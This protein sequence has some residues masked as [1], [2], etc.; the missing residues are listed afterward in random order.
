MLITVE[1]QSSQPLRLSPWVHFEPSD[2]EMRMLYVQQLEPLQDPFFQDNMDPPT[3]QSYTG[4]Q[5]SAAGEDLGGFFHPSGFNVSVDQPVPPHYY[6]QIEASPVQGDNDPEHDPPEFVAPQPV[7][8]QAAE[9]ATPAALVDTLTSCQCP[10]CGRL[11]KRDQEKRRHIRSFLP[12]W[13]YCHS[14]G[15]SFRCDRRDS[16]VSHWKG[17]HAGSGQAP[18]KQQRSQYEIY[19]P[20]PFVTLIVSGQMLMEIVESIALS[21]VKTRA[22]ELG[23]GSAWEENWFGRRRRPHDEH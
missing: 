5:P 17:K 18:Q 16:L 10:I 8:D 13:I 11:F 15:C 9:L 12:H 20:E 23:K 21:E 22:E 14:P 4:Q 7:Q 2:L 1:M 19:D 6:T 3:P